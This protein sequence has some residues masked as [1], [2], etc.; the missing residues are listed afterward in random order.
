MFRIVL[1][2]MSGGVF[3][4]PR[5]PD[6]FGGFSLFVSPDASLKYWKRD[7]P[8]IDSFLLAAA[9]ALVRP[10]GAV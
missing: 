2:R 3:L 6:G 1:E 9:Q 5:L 8:N 10:D 4:R 7:L